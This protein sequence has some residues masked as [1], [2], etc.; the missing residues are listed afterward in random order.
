MWALALLIELIRHK[1]RGKLWPG[2]ELNP[3][4]SGL[5][6]AACSCVI[7]FI[8]LR[9]SGDQQTLYQGIY[10]LNSLAR[11][12]VHK[13]HPCVKRNFVPVCLLHCVPPPTTKIRVEGRG[14]NFRI[15]ETFGQDVF[16]L[17][18]LQQF[19]V[20]LFDRKP[21]RFYWIDTALHTKKEQNFGNS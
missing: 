20:R 3:G 10:V 2:W 17:C 18:N 6:T 11:K 4:P 12:L 9:L 1:D 15:L 5:I 8:L 21:F 7:F 19:E 16:F 13:S 14:G